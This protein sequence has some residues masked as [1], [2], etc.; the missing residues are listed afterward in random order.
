MSTI[1]WDYAKDTKVSVAKSRMQIMELLDRAGAE[2]KAF[3]DHGDRQEIQFQ[4]GGLLYA[5]RVQLLPIT[6]RRFTHNHNRHRVSSNVQK[7]KHEQ[8]A[9][10]RWRVLHLKVKTILVQVFEGSE[11]LQEL[12]FPYLMTPTGGTVAEELVPR[13]EDIQRRGGPMMALGYSGPTDA[14]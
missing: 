6:D 10:T 7:R 1:G 13:L 8:H 5:L 11:T 2:K 14:D 3:L 9:R 12:L 4:I